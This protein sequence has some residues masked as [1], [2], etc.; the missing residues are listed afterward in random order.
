MLEL[1]DL[2]SDTGVLSTYKRSSV[3]DL[4]I[5]YFNQMQALHASIE[6]AA[7]FVPT[8]PG[9][10]VVGEMEGVYSLNAATYKVVGKVKFVILDDAVLVARRRRRNAGG[11]GD[12]STVNEGK[13]V[14]E[15]C[16]ALN[17]MLVLDTK[18]S[19]NMTN[20]F[21]IRQG[22][23]THVYRTENPADK[24]T[25]LA[26][27]RQVADELAAK[28]RKEREGEH[29]RRKSMWQGGDR[30]SAIPP[31]PEWMADLA[32]RGGEFPGASEADDAKE[33]TERDARWVG[34]WSDD[35]TVAI[36]LREWTK[37]VDLVEQGQARLSTIP[38]LQTKLPNLTNQLTAAL[39]SSLSVP[40]NKKSTCVMLITL[41]IRLKAGAAARKTYL[42]MRTGVITGLMRRIRFEGD[43][44]SYVGDLSVVWFTGIKHTADWYL[45]SFKDNNES[46]SAL[47]V[48]A[49]EQLKTF[50]EMFRKQVYTKDVE[51][52]LVEES[53]EIA[54]LQSNKLLREHGLDFSYLLDQLLVE[55]PKEIEK[56]SSSFSFSAHRLSKQGDLSTL[57]QQVDITQSNSQS[58]A[59]ST[60]PSPIQTLPSAPPPPMLSA[61]PPPTRRRSPAPPSAFREPTS[62]RNGT[63]PPSAPSSSQGDSVK[64]PL[65]L[66]SPQPQMPLSSASV[67]PSSRSRT[68]VGAGSATLNPGSSMVSPMPSPIPPSSAPATGLG[69]NNLNTS[70]TPQPRRRGTPGGTNSAGGRDSPPVPMTPVGGRSN[71]NPFGSL[72]G[73]P[74]TEGSGEWG[75]GSSGMVSPTLTGGGSVRSRAPRINPSLPPRSVN[76]PGSLLAANSTGSS[77]SAT[78]SGQGQQPSPRGVVPQREGMF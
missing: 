30:S 71:M 37:A 39:L 26:Q 59:D 75:E 23:E 45:S 17:D 31:M 22:K 29:E 72:R 14:A 67:Y 69:L 3:A 43:I 5:L 44:T 12:G 40:S 20:V 46:T 13:L 2:L 54:H 77:G 50:A 65:A 62:P 42:E 48:W 70:A 27:F 8:T 32:R 76:R 57:L 38:A 4:R 19:P 60:E 33:K 73:R 6:G 15:R 25:L 68:P 7:K 41:L 52:G 36:A 64:A 28:K 78:G 35:L 66:K 16:W 61:P 55:K 51:A 11:A 21:K 10:H 24:K 34:E 18:D 49:H 9:R 63:P 58:Q 74:S 53:I 1:K 56:G 47:V